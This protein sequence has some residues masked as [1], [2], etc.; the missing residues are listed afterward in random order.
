MEIISDIFAYTLKNES[1][2]GLPAL[3]KRDLGLEIEDRL[4]RRYLPTEK[5]GQYLQVNIYGWGNKNGKKTLI[6]GETKTNIS[7]LLA[8]PQSHFE[9]PFLKMCDMGWGLLDHRSHIKNHISF[10]FCSIN[11]DEIENMKLYTRS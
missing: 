6:L 2:K 11:T 8:L 7:N 4:I 1:Y 5:K 10:D 9:H 3:L